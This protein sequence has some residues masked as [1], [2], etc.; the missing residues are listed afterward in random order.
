MPHTAG[1]PDREPVQY[2]LHHSLR[3]DLDAWLA[4]RGLEV[5]RAPAEIEGEDSLP[6]FFVFPTQ[7]TMDRALRELHPE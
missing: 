6:T 1:E 4:A 7:E 3:P 2:I 5:R